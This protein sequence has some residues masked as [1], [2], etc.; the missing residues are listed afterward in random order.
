MALNPRWQGGEIPLAFVDTRCDVLKT[1]DG[2]RQRGDVG[3]VVYKE[4]RRAVQF[5]LGAWVLEILI[6]WLVIGSQCDKAPCEVGVPVMLLAATFIIVPLLVCEFRAF[7]LFIAPFCDWCQSFRD[8][9]S[10]FGFPLSFRLFCL[11]QGFLS[12]LSHADLVTSAGFFM[13][14]VLSSYKNPEV[15]QHAADIINEVIH[16]LTFNVASGSVVS[17]DYAI[18]FLVGGSVSVFLQMLWGL[19]AAVPCRDMTRRDENLGHA[20]TW[21]WSESTVTVRSGSKYNSGGEKEPAMGNLDFIV[22]GDIHENVVFGTLLENRLGPATAVKKLARVA[23]MAVLLSMDKHYDKLADTSPDKQFSSLSKIGQQQRRDG[24]D[25]F[26]FLVLQSGWQLWVQCVWAS[27]LRK[28][29]DVS[30][31]YVALTSILVGFANCAKMMYFAAMS[32]KDLHSRAAKIDVALIQATHARL[33][34]PNIR[35]ELLN[36]ELRNAVSTEVV[37]ACLLDR[38]SMRRESDLLRTFTRDI[39]EG[40]LTALSVKNFIQEHANEGVALTTFMTNRTNSNVIL[41]AFHAKQYRF[42]YTIVQSVLLASYGTEMLIAA[43]LIY[44]TWALTVVVEVLATL[45][46]GVV[47]IVVVSH[48]ALAR[49]GVR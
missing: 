14:A 36:E 28:T 49:Y 47:F 10:F 46:V 1:K 25:A 5:L 22:E 6:M 24:Q 15:N 45:A 16:N 33:E 40:A 18:W 41:T 35:P 37:K 7:K 9:P 17:P 8:W 39:E 43:V 11:L 32:C 34:V 21:P 29:A 38:V 23:R 12:L 26:L 19:E 2:R 44:R 3:P 42:F 30:V 13:S 20:L 48:C 4:C 31:D 27:V